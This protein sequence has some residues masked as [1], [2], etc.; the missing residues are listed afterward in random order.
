MLLSNGHAEHQQE[1]LPGAFVVMRV[2][3][4]WRLS[5]S[6]VESRLPAADEEA[7]PITDLIARPSTPT[8]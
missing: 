2:G 5:A 4:R 6:C 1:A 3:L 8:R 7:V